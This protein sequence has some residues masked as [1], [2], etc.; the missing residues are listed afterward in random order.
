MGLVMLDVRHGVLEMRLLHGVRLALDETVFETGY[1][2]GCGATLPRTPFFL[3]R[4]GGSRSRCRSRGSH[5]GGVGPEDLDSTDVYSST[6][7]ASAG[8]LVGNKTFLVVQKSSEL[9]KG[10][11]GH[12]SLGG[13]ES[14][15]GLF[16]LRK[17]FE[18]LLQHGEQLLLVRDE[19]GGR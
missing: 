11:I 18:R 5:G 16:E 6:S 17:V 15:H 1:H 3:P 2:R 13:V 12:T 8:D 10:L 4:G 19:G 9:F 7:E 14:I